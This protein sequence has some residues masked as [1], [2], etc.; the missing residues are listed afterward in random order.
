MQ[1]NL[2]RNERTEIRLH[3]LSTGFDRVYIGHIDLQ[4]HHD[5]VRLFCILHGPYPELYLALEELVRLGRPKTIS[6]RKF[7]KLRI[8][9]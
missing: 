4:C 2:E 7:P 9:G 6:D 5:L 8:G 1:F 3:L